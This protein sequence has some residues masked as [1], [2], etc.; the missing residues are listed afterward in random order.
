VQKVADALSAT[1][2][3]EEGKAVLKDMKCKELVR[4]EK[5]EYVALIKYLYPDSAP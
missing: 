2:T 5:D 1:Y 4:A 3:N